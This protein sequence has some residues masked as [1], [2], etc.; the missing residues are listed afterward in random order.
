MSEMDDF[1]FDEETPEEE[2]EDW[3]GDEEAKGGG[4]TRLLLLILLLV[5]L[6]G[7]GV[8]FFVLAP[9]DGPSPPVQVVSMPKKPVAMPAQPST[10]APAKPQT[11]APAVAPAPSPAQPATTA[12]AP[13]TQT[14]TPAAAAKPAPTP[15]AVAKP[16]PATAQTTEPAVKTVTV[17]PKTA[18]TAAPATRPVAVAS[19]D[20]YT[21]NA[22]AY[23]LKSNVDD[24]AKRI[25]SAG[26][27]PVLT[28]VTRKVK[29][30]RLLVGRYPTALDGARK[31]K[32]VKRFA[33][34]AFTIT[35]GSSVSVYVGSYVSR[36]K[37][38]AYADRLYDKRGLQLQEEE[39]LIKESLQQVTFGAF[40]TSE[41]AKAVA[42]QLSG[43]G[44]S[45][46]PQ[47]RR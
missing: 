33:P 8:W 24:L 36:E 26:Y 37:A 19:G 21:L 41:E 3:G 45:A 35:R 13:T 23:L 25:R 27:E 28:P 39:A 15:A 34:D 20:A 4:R 31:L 14:A 43:N 29:M 40:A 7:A 16:A 38:R 9:A 30:L 10:Q 17:Q 42:R 1:G 47:A 11:A 12:G 18:A 6:A 2:I 5:V 22:G 46:Q 44:I 32:E